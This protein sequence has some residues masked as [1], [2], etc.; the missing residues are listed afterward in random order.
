MDKKTLILGASPNPERYAHRAAEML[1][2]AGIAFVPVGIR[3]GKCAGETI[4]TEKKPFPQIHT[5]TLYVGP[6]NQAAWYPYVLE[7]KPQRLIF[8]P[9]TENPELAD[10]AS[11]QGI[12]CVE[13]CTL[14]LL[15]TG[16]Y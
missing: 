15:A 3:A 5:L 6:E 4:V 16:Q 8:N 1:K 14:V 13:A 10:L 2:N 9:G 11:A 12:D 7:T